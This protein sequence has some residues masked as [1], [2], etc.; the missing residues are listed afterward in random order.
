MFIQPSAAAASHF[1]SLNGRQTPETKGHILL[2][3]ALPFSCT[4]RSEQGKC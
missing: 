1:H 4:A 3:L 2:P